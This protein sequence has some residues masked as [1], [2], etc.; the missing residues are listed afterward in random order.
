MKIITDEQIENFKDFVQNHDFLFVISH[1]EPD[2]DAIF[3]S[4]AMGA[5]LE[6]LGK[7]HQLLSAGPFKRTEIRDCENLFSNEL[8]NLSAEEK[9]SAGLIVL[10]C[11]ES[12][13]FG[14]ISGDLSVFDAFVIDHHKTSEAT[15]NS[16]IDASSPATACLV[17]QLYEKIIGKIP[18]NVSKWLF[19]GISTDTGYFR[20]LREDSAEVFRLAANLVESGASPREIYDKISSGKAYTTR[21]LLSVALNRAF[22]KCG[23]KLAVTYETQEDTRRFGQDG[24]DSDALYSLLRRCFLS[25]K[26]PT[27]LARRACVRAT[28]LM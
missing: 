9:K 4:L 1:K 11:S 13:R 23:E 12:S 14:E 19:S 15:K 27:R 28:A 25:G 2:G 5:L 22:R 6:S 21:K 24:R 20:F 3:S 10:D 18:Q 8:K 26:I 7:N 17:Q 16:I